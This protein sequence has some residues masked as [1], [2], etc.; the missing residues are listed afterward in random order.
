MLIMDKIGCFHIVPN[1]L[2]HVTNKKAWSRKKL[3]RARE[4]NSLFSTLSF[5]YSLLILFRVF[6]RLTR[7]YVGLEL[8]S[9]LSTFY[10]LLSTP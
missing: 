5:I 2:A 10:Y 1:L 6:V 8:I 4:L 9:L 7:I 3:E